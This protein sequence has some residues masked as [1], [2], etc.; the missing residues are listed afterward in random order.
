[1]LYYGRVVDTSDQELMRLCRK[2]DER[3]W[4]LLMDRYERLVFSIPLNYGLSREDAADVTQITSTVLIQSLKTPTEIGRLGPWLATVARRHTWRLLERGQRESTSRHEDLA[5]SAKLVGK[6]GSGSVEH[7]ELTEWLHHGL[8]SIDEPCRELLLALYFD[9]E[10]PSYAEV[11]A[12]LNRPVGSI[13]PTRGRCLK[14]LRKVMLR[15]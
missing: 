10:Q 14:E 11:A 15:G 3:A 7:W 5:E 8:S 13:G 12:R 1:M 6:S 4:E 2:G 9:P